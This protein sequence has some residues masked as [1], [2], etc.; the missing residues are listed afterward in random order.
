M[1]ELIAIQMVSSPDVEENLQKVDAL[2]ST[3]TFNDE[4]LVVLPECFSRFGGGDKG[5][6]EIAEQPGE[7]RIQTF[8]ASLSKQYGIWLVAGTTP[9]KSAEQGKFTASSLMFDPNGR[10]VAEY[11]KIHLFDVTVADNT[12]TYYESRYT[13]GGN[14]VVVVETP[15][16]R[17]GMAVCYDIRF[18]GLFQA[19]GQIDILVLPAAFT[20]RTGEAHW[21]KLLTA[22][23]IEN[24]CYLVAADQGGVHAN[25]RK[26][27]GHSCIISPWGDVICEIAKGEG[28]IQTPLDS[29]LI[30]QTRQA[31][32]VEQHNKFRSYLV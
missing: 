14:K 31:M 5:L 3:I 11:Q 25:G 32:P 12:G 24:Q 30:Q 2:L 9:L 15:L 16:G 21:H 1:A 13:D 10:Q 22:R 7:G 29:E 19:M 17:V 28:V 18:A 4:T 20:E 27:F 6:L 23:A 8:L 26:T